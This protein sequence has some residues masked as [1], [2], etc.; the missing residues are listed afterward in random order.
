MVETHDG[1]KVD[2]PVSMTAR[3]LV[4]GCAALA[5]VVSAATAW[6]QPRDAAADAQN[7][8]TSV[9]SP[10]CP[11]RLLADCPSSAAFELRAEILHRLESGESAADV[12]RD[13]YRKLGDSIRA[14]PPPTRL[15]HVLSVM[16]AIVLALSGG[17]LLWFLARHRG[18]HQPE[19][20]AADPA[21]ED[22]LQQELDKVEEA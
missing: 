5:I 1:L 2:L 15:G 21:M 8:F 19:W 13:L 18:D 20:A 7:I 4:I 17:A 14:I 3:R 11:G 12:E 16:P 6:P 9:M 10:Y 22:R